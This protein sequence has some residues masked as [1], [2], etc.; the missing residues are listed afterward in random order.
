VRGGERRAYD[1]AVAEQL[2]EYQQDIIA[3]P[4]ALTC[5]SE[6]RLLS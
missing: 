3:N 2:K 4:L 1:K 6:K 5:T